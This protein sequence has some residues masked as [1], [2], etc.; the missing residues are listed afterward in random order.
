MALEAVRAILTFVLRLFWR[1]EFHGRENIPQF[2]PV[3]LVA[4]HP[5]YTDPVTI[6]VGAPVRPVRWMTWDAVF[7]VPFL[8]S[9][10]KLFGAYP[11][12]V[13][14]TPKA[15][16][17]ASLSLL[18]R[19]ELIGVFPE[20][21]RSYQSLMGDSKTGA[22]RLAVRSGAPI[23]PVSVAG[24]YRAWPRVRRLPRTGR[25]SVTYH[26]PIHLYSDRPDREFYE[27]AMEQVKQTI[28]TGLC[29]TY[30]EWHVRR[31]YDPTPEEFGL[32]V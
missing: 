18:R 8:G 5:S 9:L 3:I 11:I 26:P 4:N 25:I 1:I 30:A 28:N 13:D 20:G 17:E 27:R 24:A 15:A 22:I 12:D 29:E 10:V 31:I 19:G 23:V 2:G 16:F 7:R 14:S 6:H 21:G 32:V